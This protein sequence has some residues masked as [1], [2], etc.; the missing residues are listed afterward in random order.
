VAGRRRFVAASARTRACPAGSPYYRSVILRC[1]RRLLDAIKPAHLANDAPYAEDW[2]ANLLWFDGRK[3]L[4]LTHV[5]TLFTV[6]EP[7]V[8]VA[9]LRDT[10]RLVT[11]VIARELAREE[12]PADT[13]G[14]LDPAGVVL[15][16]TA[17]RSVLAHMTA[18]ALLCEFMIGED[19]GLVA[20]DIDGI[21]DRLRRDPIGTRGYQM[22]IELT[23]QR[24]QRERF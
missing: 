1:T 13:F 20:A 16:K 21:N 12:L 23:L 8:R 5:A 3:C 18:M 19:G 14:S 4:L 24:T 7:D 11:A 17:D 6:L 9:A 15:A 10:G 2:Y 22:P